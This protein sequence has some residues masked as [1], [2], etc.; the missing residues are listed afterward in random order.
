MRESAFDVI[1]SMIQ[2][3]AN[4]KVKMLE[5][6]VEAGIE[7]ADEWLSFEL[8]SNSIDYIIGKLRDKLEPYL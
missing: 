3:L 5:L 2:S 1:E 6:E 8:E 4:M 7:Y